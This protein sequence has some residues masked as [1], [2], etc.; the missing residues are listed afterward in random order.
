[1]N[2]DYMRLLEMPR[3]HLIKVIKRTTIA[4]A[5]LFI[6]VLQIYSAVVA[7]PLF[8]HP[9]INKSGSYMEYSFAYFVPNSPV[10]AA[11]FAAYYL[12]VFYFIELLRLK[13]AAATLGKRAGRIAGRWFKRP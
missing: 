12:L 11:V 9:A 13:G 7:F 4:L 8:L 5:F 1:M 3:K 10:T 2:S 6:P